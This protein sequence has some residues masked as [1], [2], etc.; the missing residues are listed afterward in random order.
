VSPRL[1][2]RVSSLGRIRA[3]VAYLIPDLGNVILASVGRAAYAI[4]WLGMGRSSRPDPKELV[5]GRGTSAKERVEKV[6]LEILHPL[7]HIR[8]P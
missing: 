2:L 7:G 6:S 5:S 8:E 4:D 1:S 3:H